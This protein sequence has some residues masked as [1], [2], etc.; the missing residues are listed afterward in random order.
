M[1][2]KKH[3]A[4]VGAGIGGMAA[5]YDLIQAGYSVTIFDRDDFV[6]GLASGIK[7]RFDG[8]LDR[9]SL[10]FPLPTPEA[11]RRVVEELRKD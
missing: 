5:A 6:G 4:I 3:V 11:E 10:Y 9:T 7:E 1:D 8:L 2:E